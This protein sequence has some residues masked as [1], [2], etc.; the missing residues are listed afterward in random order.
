MS[1]FNRRNAVIGWL[2]WMAG[3]S[4]LKQKAKEAVPAIDAETK[5]PNKSAIAL[6][7]AGA[8]GA[9]T[10]AR[11]RSGDGPPPADNA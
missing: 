6:L 4:A 11:R 10:F 3:K 2:V 9:A 1:V 5:K 8:V 7:L